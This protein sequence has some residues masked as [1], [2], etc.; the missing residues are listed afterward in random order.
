VIW[1]EKQGMWA[2]EYQGL[3]YSIAQE[4]DPEY[5]SGIEVIGNKWENPELV[6]E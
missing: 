4:S 6:E 1:D 5:Y 3:R 2:G